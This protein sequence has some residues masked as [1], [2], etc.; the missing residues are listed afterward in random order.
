MKVAR[1][2]PAGSPFVVSRTNCQQ[3]LLGTGIPSALRDLTTATMQVRSA[4]VKD[5]ALTGLLGGPCRTVR[6]AHRVAILEPVY[7]GL[8]WA[9]T[10]VTV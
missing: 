9:R 5:M 1:G 6:I 4:C 10:Q 3:E 8:I 2:S 7:C